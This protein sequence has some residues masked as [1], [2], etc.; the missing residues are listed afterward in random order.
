MEKR[1]TDW[2][3]LDEVGE[4]GVQWKYIYSA[5]DYLMALH[6]SNWKV[7]GKARAKWYHRKSNAWMIGLGCI[8]KGRFGLTKSQLCRELVQGKIKQG[9]KK[10]RL[11]REVAQK[12][13]RGWRRWESIRAKELSWR[14]LWKVMPRKICFTISSLYDILLNPNNFCTSNLRDEPLFQ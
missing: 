6:E 3:T 8:A 5:F 10:A 4:N 9:K 11:T 13:Q 1:P 2:D 12:T 14:D 7:L